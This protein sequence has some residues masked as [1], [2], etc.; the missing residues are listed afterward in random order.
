MFGTC[1]IMLV[2]SYRFGGSLGGVI[3]ALATSPEVV[4]SVVADGTRGREL[5]LE[6]GDAG[7]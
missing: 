4:V 2:A 1:V 5:A 6:I 7:L 3:T